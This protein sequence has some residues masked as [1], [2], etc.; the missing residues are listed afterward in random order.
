MVNSP[1]HGILSLSWGITD[2]VLGRKEIGRRPR[3]ARR[4]TVDVVID[5]AGLGAQIPSR[6]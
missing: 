3:Y 2:S 4:P 6:V 1:S 5:T